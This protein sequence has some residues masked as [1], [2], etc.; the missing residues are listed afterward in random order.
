ML[1]ID[2]ELKHAN[3]EGTHTHLAFRIQPIHACRL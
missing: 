2:P 3:W 1:N